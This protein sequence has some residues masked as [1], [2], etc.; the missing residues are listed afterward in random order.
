MHVVAMTRGMG[1]GLAALFLVSELVSAQ[2]PKDD[3]K[4]VVQLPVGSLDTKDWLKHSTKPFEA[5]E[6]DRLINAELD[7]AIAADPR[8]LRPA[9]A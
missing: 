6:I 2:T 9:T 7:Y 5:G 4:P 1:I 8:V 3:K